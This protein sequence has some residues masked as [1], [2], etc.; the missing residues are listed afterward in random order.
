M[1]N[2]ESEIRL[3]NQKLETLTK[4][5]EDDRSENKEHIK[6]AQGFRDRVLTLEEKVKSHGAEHVYYRWL[7]GLIITIGLALLNK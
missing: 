7:F 3:I 2:L 4:Y 1:D 6:S 5:I